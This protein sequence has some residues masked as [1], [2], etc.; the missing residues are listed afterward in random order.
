V[1]FFFDKKT[2]FS[3]P[4]SYFGS[5]AF[6]SEQ[7]LI[8]DEPHKS[9]RRWLRW[10]RWLSGWSVCS[11]MRNGVGTRALWLIYLAIE[12]WR[13]TNQLIRLP[14]E[15]PQLETCDIDISAYRNL[16]VHRSIYDTVLSACFTLEALQHMSVV[17]CLSYS[18]RPPFHRTHIHGPYE[19]VQ[20]CYP[21]HIL[22]RCYIRCSD[23]NMYNSFRNRVGNVNYACKHTIIEFSSVS[24]SQRTGFKEMGVPKMIRIAGWCKLIPFAADDGA[25]VLLARKVQLVGGWI[26]PKT[27]HS[28]TL[29]LKIQRS[30]HAWGGW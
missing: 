12:T 13:N 25:C 1:F 22:P 17:I 9:P 4:R 15:F 23:N 24:Q 20:W 27:L 30:F 14:A 28:T 16:G 18:S 3:D 5:I 19:Y 7:I 21:G 2:L 10:A 29:G 11:N 6:A 8:Q 26:I